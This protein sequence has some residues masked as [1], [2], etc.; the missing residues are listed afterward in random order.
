MF[1]IMDILTMEFEF[2][3][4]GFNWWS[5][6]PEFFLSLNNKKYKI[7][8]C[9]RLPERSFHIGKYGF[10]LCSRCTGI[11]IGIITSLILIQLSFGL[12]FIASLLLITPLIFDGFLQLL[13]LKESNNILRFSTGLLFGLALL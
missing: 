3:N 1:R 10:P 2:K 13:N 4:F 9:H 5:L 8:F 7:V 11:F 12:P 6:L